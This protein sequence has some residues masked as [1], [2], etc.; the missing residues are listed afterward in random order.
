MYYMSYTM[1]NILSEI[2]LD[3]AT[4]NPRNDKLIKTF[5]QNVRKYRIT[6]KL[7]MIQ[8]AGLCD[9]EYGAISTIERG[10]VNCSISTAYTIANALEVKLDQLFE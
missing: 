9:V 4:K 5:G 1:Q 7:T 10:I 8:L 3:M 2:L 6:K